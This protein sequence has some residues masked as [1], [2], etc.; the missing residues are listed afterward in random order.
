[1]GR[2]RHG[3]R[4]SVFQEVWHR[5]RPLTPTA[6]ER[7][8]DFYAKAVVEPNRDSL[9]VLGGWKYT[10]GR[11][12]CDVTLYRFGSVAE[13]GA[14]MASFGQEAEYLEEVE[15]LFRETTIEERRTV[16][17]LAPIATWERLDE[18][19]AEQPDAPRRYLQVVRSM[20]LMEAARAYE[21]LGRLVEEREKRGS[22][23]LVTAYEPM[24]GEMSQLTEIWVLPPG[25]T[26]LDDVAD[27]VDRGLIDEIETLVPATELLYMAP[28]SYSRLR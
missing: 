20:P 21:L 8:I 11:T 2:R 19:L 18:V 7:F 3:S 5:I 13:I 12:N 14:S 22:A 16:A 9:D 1:M 25:V 28:V 27:A 24:I 10:A 4:V 15:A 6:Y 26:E 17:A 23:R